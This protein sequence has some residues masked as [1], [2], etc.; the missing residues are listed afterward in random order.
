MPAKRRAV[1]PDQK[2]RLDNG[3]EAFLLG[4]D[5]PQKADIVRMRAWVL[6]VS[7]EIQEGIKWNSISFKTTEFFATVNLR[8][9]EGVQ[10]VLHRGAK[11]RNDGV[12]LEQKISDP[13]G[14][15][16]WRDKDRS[17]LTVG[18]GKEFQSARGAIAR[19]IRE[20]IEFV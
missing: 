3:V 4:L 10:L 5:H 15:L 6:A 7:P 18:T 20:W 11:A 19:V 14:L 13:K 9:K 1:K 12:E 8:Y 16:D 17:L 2:Q